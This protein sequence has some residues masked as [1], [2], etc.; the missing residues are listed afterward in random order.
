[1]PLVSPHEYKT[2]GK[3]D[4]LWAFIGI[5]IPVP[6]SQAKINPDFIIKDWGFS[7]TIALSKFH[8]PLGLVF[9]PVMILISLIF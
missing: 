9:I 8:V 3:Y 6:M 4:T 1:M 2:L 5:F 7:S